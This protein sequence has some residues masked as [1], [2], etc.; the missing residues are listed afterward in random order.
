MT[1]RMQV[2][3]TGLPEKPIRPFCFSVGPVLRQDT[4]WGLNLIDILIYEEEAE[5][6]GV[7]LLLYN[8]NSHTGMT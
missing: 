1:C 6:I 2:W 5:W 8:T 3:S 4:A 7:L